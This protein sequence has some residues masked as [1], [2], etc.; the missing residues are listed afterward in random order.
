MAVMAPLSRLSFH[1]L[2][3]VLIDPGSWRGW[4]EP[5]AAPDGGGDPAY[6]A[7]LVRASERTGLDE[8]VVTG[9]A[10]IR[11]H[12]VAVAGCEFGFLAGSIG[13]AA[14]DR[15]CRAVERATAE[16]IALLGLPA[17]GGTRMQEGTPAFVQMI[18]VAGAIADHRAA[19]LPY[20]VYL[21]DPTTG[22][23]YA[24]WGSLGQV[25]FAQPGALIAFLG[26]RVYESLRGQSFPPG[27]QSAEN[28]VAHGVVDAVVV[29]R[30]LAAAVAT[31]LAVMAGPRPALPVPDGP[32][33]AEPV[34]AAPVPAAPVAES[35]R[36]S[37]RADRPGVRAL[38]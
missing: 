6:A 18:K 11:G 10:R 3:D 8:A 23:A 30:D 27:G 26:P 15:L 32:D 35:L 1:E 16:R 12:R 22:G 38:L 37:R 29:P 2:L 28:L 24:S 5:I 17:S 7:D 4:N 13:V 33:P 25:T 9:E 34:P 20:L 31:A 14:G 21:R 19:G 36:R